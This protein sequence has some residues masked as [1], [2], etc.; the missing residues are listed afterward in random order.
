MFT[1]VF[2]N[3]CN[4]FFVLSISSTENFVDFLDSNV[5]Y[6]LSLPLKSLMKMYLLF[7]YR[8]D[9][10]FWIWVQEQF[11]SRNEYLLCEAFLRS[12]S[13]SWYFIFRMSEKLR[14]NSIQRTI[15]VLS[16]LY[17]HT[18]TTAD[19]DQGFPGCDLSKPDFCPPTWPMWC[20]APQKC[21]TIYSKSCW[22]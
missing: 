19:G 20:N 14:T 5:K 9:G 10:F 18:V 15:L 2:G 4:Y 21:T 3:H 1:K 22:W 6:V 17:L 7:Q 12:V 8:N 11:L 16:Y 13:F